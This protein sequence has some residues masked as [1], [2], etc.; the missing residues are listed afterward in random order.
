MAGQALP[1]RFPCWCK[2]IYSWGGEVSAGPAPVHCPPHIA[3][4]R[5][6]AADQTRSRIHRRRPDRGAQ[7]RRRLVV[8]GPP[9]A[10]PAHGRAV[11]QQLC[12]AAQRRLPAVERGSQWQLRDGLAP[13]QRA[14]PAQARPSEAEEHVQEALH[15]LC[16]CRRPEPRRRRPREAAPGSNPPG[17]EDDQALLVHEARLDR[18]P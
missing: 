5:A 14:G 6:A 2:A 18:E 16:S 8:D 17:R 7:R 4:R 12:R 3:D 13:E 10:R 9:E 15:R 11:P 1:T